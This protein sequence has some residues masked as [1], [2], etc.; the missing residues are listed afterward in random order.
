M[1]NLTRYLALAALTAI[2]ALVLAACGGDDPTATPRPTNTP[3]PA[4]EPT[5]TATLAPGVPTP[6][7]RPATPTPA[8]TPTPSFDGMAYFE[9]KTVKMI[10][11]TN[12]GGGYDTMLRIFGKVANNHFPESTKFVVQNLSGAAQLRGLQAVLSSDPDGYTIGPTHQRWFIRQ[13]LFGDVENLEFENLNVIGSPT[14]KPNP[15]MLCVDTSVATSWQDVL[16]KGVKLVTGQTGPGNSPGAGFVELLG[17]P[18]KNVYG[19]GG[20]AEVMAAFDRGEINVVWSCGPE[21]AGRLFPEWLEQG[22]LAPLYWW[23]LQHDDDWMAKIGVPNSEVPHIFDIGGVDWTDLNKLAFQSHV[24]ISTISRTFVLP[25][26]VDPNVTEFW[27]TIFKD[28]VEDPAFIE[29]A[30][31]AGYSDQYGYA[32]G[33]EIKKALVKLGQL[34]DD[35]KEILKGI[36]PDI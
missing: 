5:P 22:R 34:P 13:A 3:V 18:L 26:G 33:V 27:R 29:A 25:P 14:F 30:D 7:P 20:S 12:P 9:N 19:Y 32:G 35:V 8:P 17:G 10:T 36:T 31:I 4:P 11:G 6:T 15:N 1:K 24:E 23:E 2:A 21:L 28:V 16:D